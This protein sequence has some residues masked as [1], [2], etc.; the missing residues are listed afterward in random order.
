[1]ANEPTSGNLIDIADILQTLGS[2]GWTG[3]LEV[4]VGDQE[5][6]VFLYYKNGTIQHAKPSSERSALGLMLYKLRKIDRADL[7]F[8]LTK[9]QEIGQNFGATCQHYGFVT[10]SDIN[11]ALLFRGREEVLS[12]F[13]DKHRI[14]TRPHQGEDPLPE[15]FNKDDTS[16]N[17]NLN[18]M[19]L[20]ME[21]ARREDEWS[22][23]KNYIP[24]IDEVFKRKDGAGPVGVELRPIYLLCDGFRTAQEVARYSPWPSFEA[25]GI[26]RELCEQGFIE[27]VDALGLARAAV[28]A[29]AENDAEKALRLF[30]LAEER[31]LDRIEVSERIALAHQH[32]G[33]KHLA[34]KRWIGYAVRALDH[35]KPEK[36]IQAYRNAI[37]VDA[38]KV[39]AYTDLSAL[40][41]KLGRPDEAAQELRNLIETLTKADDPM[42]LLQAYV[43]YLELRPTDVEA[44]R[45]LAELH[46][47]QG[48]DPEAVQR[49]EQLAKIYK[50]QGQNP[51]AIAAFRRMIQINEE[52]IIGRVALA[53]TLGELGQ[54]Q[55]AVKEY[56]ALAD[57]LNRPHLSKDPTNTAALIKVYE[58]IVEIDKAEV[59]AW[60]HLA[61]AY[62]RENKEDL[63]VSCYMGL[64]Q[65]LRA[66]QGRDKETIEAMERVIELAPERIDVRRHLAR[67]Y[68]QIK[69]KGHAVKT[70]MDMAEYA[71]KQRDKGLAR[72]S[73]RG[74]L[75]VDPLNL[76]ARIGL[77]RIDEANNKFDIAAR[78]WRGIGGIA[79]RAGLFEIAERALR[80]ALELQKDHAEALRDL[81]DAKEGLMHHDEA[82]EILARYANLML[83]QENYGLAREAL[84]RARALSP[85]HPELVALAKNMPPKPA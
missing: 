13:M 44:L 20:L 83:G 63:A 29:E 64:V 72:E 12:L 36:A 14:D 84:E 24:T 5:K 55:E 53:R 33:H 37:G 3:T 31:G 45:K 69:D 22:V 35:N 56:K 81:A 28:A 19:G 52:H 61:Q 57:I 34:V 15:V 17:L 67:Y 4:I 26:L 7:N 46:A 65:A 38:S 80:H 68:L 59:D 62:D 6:K 41:V 1:M 79:V 85:N 39:E 23:N 50:E 10:E 47:E 74:A 75:E 30:E 76:D 21:A 27:S 66:T 9:Q 70:Y 71:V 49:F 82:T 73:Y 77:A 60:Q 2:K 58:A 42:R 18:P 11:E 8:A 43:K 16:T 40:L 78:R 54:V 32:L 25:Y 51:Q 48:E